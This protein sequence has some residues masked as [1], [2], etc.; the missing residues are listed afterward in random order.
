VKSELGGR[1][2]ARGAFAEAETL[3]VQGHKALAADNRVRPQYLESSCQR[4]VALY[5][6]W[7]RPQQAQAW[8]S[9]APH[10]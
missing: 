6:A 8:R 2:T 9:C 3:L 10:P 5:G 1:L 7:D 4:L